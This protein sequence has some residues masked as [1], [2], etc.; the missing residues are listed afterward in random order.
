MRVVGAEGVGGKRM[1]PWSSRRAR[2]VGVWRRGGRGFG[3]VV[4]RA[5]GWGWRGMDGIVGAGLGPLD[6]E[7]MGWWCFCARL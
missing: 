3:V 7:V 5:R 2:P 4:V 6:G 1:S